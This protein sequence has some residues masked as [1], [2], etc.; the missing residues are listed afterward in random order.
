MW[1][2]IVPFDLPTFIDIIDDFDFDDDDDDNRFRFY[3]TATL[4]INK[5]D[6]VVNRYI[7]R[8]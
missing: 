2:S 3:D 5:D 7:R 6:F 4:R 8:L 1:Y